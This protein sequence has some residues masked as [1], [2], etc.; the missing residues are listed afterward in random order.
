MAH[1]MVLM[2]EEI[3]HLRE[4][5]T[6]IATRKKRKRIYIPNPKS[7]TVSEIQ[8][9]LATDASSMRN[10]SDKPVKRVRKERCCDIYRQIGH[11]A[12][13]YIVEISSLD[14]SDSSRE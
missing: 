12:R 11:N 1:K 10:I 8:D 4:I 3:K 5:A 9:L 2:R 6:T 7:L 13:T 14:N